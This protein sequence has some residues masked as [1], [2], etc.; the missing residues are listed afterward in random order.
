[1]RKALL[2]LSAFFAIPVGAL[3]QGVMALPRAHLFVIDANSKLVGYAPTSDP[4]GYGISVTVGF[5]AVGARKL[6]SI[7]LRMI[8][9]DVSSGHRRFHWVTG[10]LGFESADCTGQA[11][12]SAPPLDPSGR[13]VGAI[14]DGNVLFVSGPDPAFEYPALLSSR[15]AGGT[16]NEGTPFARTFAVNPTISLDTVWQGPFSTY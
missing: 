10:M 15:I 6:D 5:A 3:A 12:V 8:S 4:I 7:V 14:M 16:C 11:Y 2:L 9:D 1:M 13:R